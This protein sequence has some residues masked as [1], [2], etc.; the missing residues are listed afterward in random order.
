MSDIQINL[1]SWAGVSTPPQRTLVS[2]EAELWLDSEKLLGNSKIWFKNSYHIVYTLYY[3]I[4]V[5][6]KLE[7]DL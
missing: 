2:D 7:N 5:K 3:Y 6:M 4:R 1:D